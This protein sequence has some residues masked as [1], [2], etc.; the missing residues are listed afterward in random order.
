[1][2]TH[3]APLLGIREA[4]KAIGVSHITVSRYLQRY[5]ELNHGTEARPL[6]KLEELRWHRR[7]NI[8]VETPAAVSLIQASAE[9]VPDAA[10]VKSVQSAGTIYKHLRPHSAHGGL[11]PEAVLI[12][13]AGDRQQHLG[14]GHEINGRSQPVTLI[15]A[16]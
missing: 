12:R 5:P 8:D 3:Q 16:G 7:E 15:N 1:M 4:A 2:T 14:H 13:S 10:P 9:Q 6:V 11:S